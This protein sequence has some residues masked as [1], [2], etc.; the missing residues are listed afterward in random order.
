MFN[1]FLFTK[2]PILIQ[3][4]YYSAW[5]SVR[6]PDAAHSQKKILQDFARLTKVNAV[7][8]I[9]QAHIWQFA[10]SRSTQYF[11]QEA[12]KALRNFL[13]YARM[14]GYVETVG[15]SFTMNKTASPDYIHPLLHLDQVARIK[16]LRRRFVK[17]KPMTFRAIQEYLKGQDNRTY[18]LKM[19]NRWANYPISDDKLSTS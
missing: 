10:D 6:Y 18:D 12:L 9:T 14:V 5:R 16:Q 8:D 17:G 11:Q 4:D 19:L 7:S 15:I 3:V 1:V 2:K 13:T